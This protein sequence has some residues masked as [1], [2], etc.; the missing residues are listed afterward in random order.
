LESISFKL[1]KSFLFLFDKFLKL[2]F[3]LFQRVFLVKGLKIDLRGKVS[4]AGNSKKRHYLIKYGEFSF[5]KKK[6][7]ISYAQNIVCTSTGVLGLELI[8]VY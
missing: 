4:A 2:F 6:N 5:S 1:H 3:K 8:L 7:K